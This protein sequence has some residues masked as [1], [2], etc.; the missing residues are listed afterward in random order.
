MG[1]KRRSLIAGNWK[2]NGLSGF[3]NDLARELVVKAK[4]AKS[5][6]FDLL[7]CPP[8]TLLSSVA[9]IISETGIYLGGQDCHIAPNGAHTGDI[10]AEMLEDLGCKFI[11]V[12]HSERRADCFETN[13]IVKCKAEAA[14]RANLIAIICVGET[15]TERKNGAAKEIVEGQI[16]ASIPNQGNSANIIIAYEPVWAIGTGQTPTPEEVQEIHSLMREILTKEFG[17]DEATQTRLLYG[18]SVKPGNAIELMSLP[19]VDGA[20]VGGASLLG[21][22]FW[23]IA[24]SCPK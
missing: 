8:A 1:F 3:A 17:N 22:D 21:R 20:L 6:H 19:D 5:T 16:L 18:G 4:G 7:I 24:E 9:D 2:M 10:S 14:L 23:E 15:E 13:E 12:G 11:I